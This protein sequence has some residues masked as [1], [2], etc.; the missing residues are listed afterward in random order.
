MVMDDRRNKLIFAAARNYLLTFPNVDEGMIDKH[1]N[2][3]KEG[4]RNSLN[5]LLFG[6][7]NSVQN[8]QGMQDRVFGKL[9][10]LQPYLENYDPLQ[11]AKRYGDN[12]SRDWGKLFVAIQNGYTPPG[13]MAIDKPRNPWVIFCKATISASHFLSRFSDVGEFD[14]F[15]SRFYLNEYTRLALPLLLDKEIFGLGFA[16][17]CDFL[18]ENGYPKF[19]KPDT[20]I[21]DIFKGLGLSQ[22]DDDYE[23]F[24]DV[25]RFSESIDEIPYVVDKLF[26]LVGSGKF[27][28]DGVT[29]NTDKDKFIEVVKE[30]IAR[31]T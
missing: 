13:K 25:I 6:M 11:I 7:L 3:R 21:K 20:H 22:Y 28:L 19:V 24:K 30:E 8:K 4:R 16:L 12:W 31:S 26:W 18:K 23:I 14:E 1:L 2:Y 27:Y 15:V 5:D 17:A 10:N 29:V 9:E